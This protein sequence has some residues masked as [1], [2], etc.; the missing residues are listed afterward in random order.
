MFDRLVESSRQRQGRRAGGYLLI[1][2]FIYALAL[3]VFVALAVIGFNPVLADEDSFLTR[4]TL[5]PIPVDSL[6]VPPDPEGP[7]APAS[8]LPFKSLAKIPHS[9]L[10]ANGP[11]RP[12]R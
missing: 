11:L 6:P 9:R 3:V 10:R 7:P 5:P 12:R 4:M 2:S 8:D 1:I